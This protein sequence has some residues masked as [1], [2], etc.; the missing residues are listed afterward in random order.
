MR[1]DTPLPLGAGG[2]KDTLGARSP[3]DPIGCCVF[4]G[5]GYPGCVPGEPIEHCSP[6]ACPGCEQRAGAIE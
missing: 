5:C 4:G 1:Y 2:L 6:T 3:T